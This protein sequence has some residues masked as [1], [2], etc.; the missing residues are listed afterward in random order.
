MNRPIEEFEEIMIRRGISVGVRA[1]VMQLNPSGVPLETMPK[2]L[3]FKSTAIMLRLTRA[4]MGKQEFLKEFG[5]AAWEALP[6]GY[7]H[8]YGKRK[9]VGFEVVQDRVH[10][11][12]LPGGLPE[13]RQQLDQ[14][15][16]NSKK[17]PEWRWIGYGR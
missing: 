1:R 7:K 13:P 10:L 6:N 3:H 2:G 4:L 12:Y 17:A 11:S 8:K 9:F 16:A 5:R 15:Y 14:R